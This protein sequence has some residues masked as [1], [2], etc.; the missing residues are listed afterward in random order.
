MRQ[1]ARLKERVGIWRDTAQRIQ[2]AL[3]L[4]ELSDDDGLTRELEAE[5]DPSNISYHIDEHDEYEFNDLDHARAVD[6]QRQDA[7]EIE[8]QIQ[9]LLRSSDDWFVVGWSYRFFFPEPDDV[10]REIKAI[11]AEME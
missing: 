3:E 8:T 9:N 5:S 7:S 2:D 11:E 1:L 10:Q 6:R 4:A